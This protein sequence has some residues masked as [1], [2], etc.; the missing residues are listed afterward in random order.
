MRRKTDRFGVACTVLCILCTVVTVVVVAPTVLDTSARTD[1]ATKAAAAG[2]RAAKAAKAAAASNRA[3]IGR[4]DRE[5][6][7]RE[8]QFCGLVLG[9]HR[10]RVKRLRN[11]RAYF[12]TSAGHERT[13]L[14]E[15]IR[16]VSLPQLEVEVAKERKRLPAVCLK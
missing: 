10:D 15:Y 2:E 9:V 1:D 4:V 3:L 16:A 6:E 13:A 7:T 12:R 5:S 11:T 14:N 8:Q